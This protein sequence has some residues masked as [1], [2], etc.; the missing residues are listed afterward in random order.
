TVIKAVGEAASAVGTWIGNGWRAFL[1]WLRNG[2]S[3]GCS[4]KG[5]FAN[6]FTGTE[7]GNLILYTEPINAD[8]PITDPCDQILLGILADE[9]SPQHISNFL[10]ISLEDLNYLMEEEHVQFLINSMSLLK[11][12]SFSTNAINHFHEA[13]QDYKDSQNPITDLE[14]V[15]SSFDDMLEK[16]AQKQNVIDFL[17]Q[18][19]YS[20][21][22]FAFLREAM[23]ALQDNDGDGQPDAEVE[24][25]DRIFELF[26]GTKVDCVHDKL[27]E[28]DLENPNI[29]LYH[30]LLNK[31]N[32]STE[33]WL[34]FEVGET[35]GDWGHTSGYA[36][37]STNT[38]FP[39]AYK[40]II[41]NDLNENGSNL[42]IM[43]TLAH[44]L[45]H[46]YMF[47]TLSDAGVILFDINTGEP[48]FDPNFSQQWCGDGSNYNGVDLNTLDTAERFKALICAMEE[49]GTLN[50]QWTHDLFNENVFSIS[51]YQQQLADFIYQ[52]HDWD[53]E[54][55]IFKNKM[56][57]NFG[58]NWK[59]KTAEACSWI[60]LVYTD[61]YTNFVNNL[62]STET[63][64]YDNIARQRMY[65]NNANSNCD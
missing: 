56:I 55:L 48:G 17:A 39:D 58:S 2:G 46:A 21:E 4:N 43:V 47:D 35:G 5:E 3:C 64:V 23:P 7:E 41:D 26:E 45:I 15:Y 52:N 54:N 65:L 37:N 34:F 20:D 6:N 51:T 11:E 19:N 32:D 25:E 33:N 59:Q 40:I 28:I 1:R 63:L 49:S 36:W 12:S 9:F 31:F 24:W 38:N 42:A 8:E 50:A 60:G 30:K 61:E 53:S 62:S 44:E 14:F 18:N 22:A 10:G 16:D 29:N 27:K 57:S 13:L